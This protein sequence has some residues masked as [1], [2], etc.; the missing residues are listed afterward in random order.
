MT[1]ENY[2]KSLVWSQWKGNKAL[3]NTIIHN[4]GLNKYV[5]STMW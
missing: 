3:S 2:S 4:A 1:T 5:V